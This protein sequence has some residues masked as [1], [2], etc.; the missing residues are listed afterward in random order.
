MYQRDGYMCAVLMNPDRYKTADSV[1]ATTEEKLTAARGAF[2][3]AG[4]YEIDVEREH[5]IHLPEVA[6]NPEYVGSRQIRPYRFEGN[7]LILTDVEKDDPAVSRW[8]I[9]WEKVQ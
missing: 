6:T 3:Y 9:I 5:I 4:R 1:L 8:K 2:F 7:R